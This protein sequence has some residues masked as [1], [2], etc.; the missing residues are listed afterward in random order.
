MR[1]STS[2]LIAASALLCAYAAAEDVIVGRELHSGNKDDSRSNYYTKSFN[3][4]EGTFGEP[5]SMTGSY[6]IGVILGFVTTAVFM[7]FGVTVIILDEVQR[8]N[9]NWRLVR[10]AEKELKNNHGYKEDQLE[11]IRREFKDKEAIRG[12]KVD[13]EKER[14]ELAAIN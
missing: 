14:Q 9:N 13:A 2:A 6:Q 12:K 10:K 1:V 7:I 3:V 11:A 4:A 8:H 5:Q